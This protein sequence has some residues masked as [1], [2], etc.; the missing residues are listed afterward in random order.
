VSGYRRSGHGNH[1]ARGLALDL[2]VRGVPKE[3]VFKVCRQLSDAGCGYY[4]ESSFVHLD[5][6]RYG[7]GHIAWVDISRSGEPPSYVAGWPGVLSPDPG[8]AA[9]E[10]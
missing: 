2:A 4:P 7:S 5:V 9:P 3:A 1:H 8:R 6:R 10:P